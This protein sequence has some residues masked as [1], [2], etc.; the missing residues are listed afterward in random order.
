MDSR[1]MRKSA[2]FVENVDKENQFSEKQR[3][4]ECLVEPKHFVA[5]KIGSRLIGDDCR[6]QWLVRDIER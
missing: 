3:V 4:T 1:P 5:V 2:Q 6:S